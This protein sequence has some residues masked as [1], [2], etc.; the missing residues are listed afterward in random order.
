V[1]FNFEAKKKNVF[2]VLMDGAVAFMI[3]LQGFQWFFDFHEEK[4]RERKKKGTK[5]REGKK[6]EGKKGKKEKLIMI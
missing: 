5:K 4:K 3:G 2:L 1:V 6:K